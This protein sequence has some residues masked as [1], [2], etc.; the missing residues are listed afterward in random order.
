MTD[1]QYQ[2]IYDLIELNLKGVPKIAPEK[3]RQVEHELLDA[4][5]QISSNTLK[6]ITHGVIAIGD[7]N[8]TD[9]R[10]VHTFSDIGT[11]QYY[12]LGSIQCVSSQWDNDNDVFWTWGEPKRTSFAIYLREITRQTQNINFWYMIIPKN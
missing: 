11:D 1:E 9:K 6:V 4:I 10:Y 2:A 8:T 12:V 7:V 3:H 5:R